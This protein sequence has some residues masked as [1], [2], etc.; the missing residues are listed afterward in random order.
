MVTAEQNNS[1][2][3]HAQ[4][5]SKN[6][7]YFRKMMRIFYVIARRDMEPNFPHSS[8][9]PKIIGYSFEDK[10]FHLS[11]G[12]GHGFAANVMPEWKARRPEWTEIFTTLDSTWFLDMIA[13]NNFSSEKAFLEKLTAHIDNVDTIGF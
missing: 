13:N 10:Y 6:H 5:T 12:K 1:T 7:R 8:N 3:P 9:W 4:P 11:Q 2:E